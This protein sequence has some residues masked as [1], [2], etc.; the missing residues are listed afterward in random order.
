[1]NFPTRDE[2]QAGIDAYNRFVQRVW[3]AKQDEI[4]VRARA[5]AEQRLR[6]EKRAPRLEW[7]ELNLA[8]PPRLEFVG[9]VDQPGP[10]TVNFRLPGEGSWSVRIKLRMRA[11]FFSSTAKLTVDR[12]RIVASIKVDRTSPIAARLLDTQVKVDLGD[13]KVDA[14]NFLLKVLRLPVNVLLDILESTIEGMVHDALAENL[15]DPKA[16]LAIEQLGLAAEPVS[17]PDAAP[18][19]TGFDAAARAVSAR[20]AQAHTPWDTVLITLVPLGDPDAP[21]AGYLRYEDSAIWSGHYLAAE[22]FRF[23]VTRDPDALINVR[24]M[25]NGLASLI[26]LTG[27]PGLL[28][29]VQV[30][31]S[32]T[33]IV[34]RLDADA[35]ASGDADVLF[36]SVDGRFRALGRI[37]RDQYAGAFLGAAVAAEWLDP[38]ELREH[39]RDI[40]R[41]MARYLLQTSFCPTHATIDQATGRKLTSTSYVTSPW[42]VLAILQAA[43]AADPAF[44]HEFDELYPI[45]SI[46]WFFNWFDTL[47]PNSSYYKFNLEHGASFLLLALERAAERRAQLAQGFQAIRWPIRYHAQAWFNLVELATLEDGELARPRSEI[48]HETKH[49]I[50]QMFERGP[51]ILPSDLADDPAIE[52]VMY[53]SLSGGEKQISRHVIAVPRRPGADFL[54]QR[55]PFALQVAW[56]DTPNYADPA[57]RSPN[58]DIVLPYWLARRLRL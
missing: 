45:W 50:A 33:A 36:T 38:G 35:Q 13:V 34:E 40:V 8:Q 20:I 3:D 12:L 58:V 19:L 56:K 29:R 21:P 5:E 42:Q 54:W 2:V 39:A 31:L 44:Q 18:T 32:E 6:Q 52:K 53:R 15:P 47:D 9:N 37:T 24:K 30:P 4:A 48:E 23:E 14:S 16:V 55:S 57:M 25:L 17:F 41:T 43:R 49:L 10:L 26:Q 7:I 11:G 46:A 28:S 27:E 51:F 1:M 22:V